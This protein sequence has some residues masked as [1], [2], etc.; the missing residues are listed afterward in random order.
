MRNFI[1]GA[2]DS[3]VST[4]G[5]LSGVA[6]AGMDRK[7]IIVTG[8]VL[9]FVEAFSMAVGTYLTQRATEPDRQQT[10]TRTRRDIL[11]SIVMLTSYFGSGLIPLLPYIFAQ[12]GRALPYSVA[13]GLA[14]LFILGI[15]SAKILKTNIARNAVRMLLMGGCAIALGVFVGTWF[16]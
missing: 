4:V 10:A 16:A 14:A 12:P 8:A 1:F 13:A 7:D 11:G 6:I 9:I 2:E 5:L 3:L 15:V